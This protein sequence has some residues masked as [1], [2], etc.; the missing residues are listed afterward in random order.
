MILLNK[1]LFFVSTTYF[2]PV[3]IAPVKIALV[4]RVNLETLF[5]GL[6]IPLM[7]HMQL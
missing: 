7:H 1:Q 2:F 4:A 5:A 3:L 6:T